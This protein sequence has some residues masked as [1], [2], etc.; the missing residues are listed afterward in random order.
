MEGSD[1]RKRLE[2]QFMKEMEE[3]KRATAAAAS[4]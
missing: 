2:I 3:W 1:E 4:V